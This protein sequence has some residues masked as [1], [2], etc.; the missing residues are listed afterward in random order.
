MYRS[1]YKLNRDPFEITPDPSFLFVTQKHNEALATLYYGVRRHKGFVVMTGEVGTGK[2]LLV[3]CLLQLL[4]H[5]NVGYAY[6]YNTK[7]SP[8]EFL[9]YIAGDLGLAASG[10]SKSDLL[11]ELN[12]Y[13]IARHQRALTTV[14]VVD[15]AHHLSVDVLEEIRLLTNLETAQQKLLQ[16]LLVGQP[17]LDEKLDSFELR[18]VKQRIALRCHLQPLNQDET[19]QYI[20]RRLQVAAANSPASGPFSA[21]AI[22]AI[23]HHSRGIPRLINT[24]CENALVIGYANQAV[25][26]MPD[27]IDE[28]AADL[29]LNIV[30]PA[31]TESTTSENDE[32]RRAVRTLLELHNSLKRAHSTKD[33]LRITMPSGVSKHEPFV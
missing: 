27:I 7:L 8:L 19:R 29:R 9:R 23:H 24:I 30:H 17:E 10:K 4:N 14:L 5:A 6:V 11:L 22:M 25:I 12:A 26:L 28:V 1:F 33:N 18:Q 15:E 3:R 21:D 2:T 20:Q 16:I 32:V 13:L 31:Q